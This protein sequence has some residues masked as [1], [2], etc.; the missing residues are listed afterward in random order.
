MK[1]LCILLCAVA[2]ASA[3][4]AQTSLRG[5]ADS[6]KKQNS[7][8][9]REGL[10][11]IKDDSMLERFKKNKYLVPIAE[12]DG[13]VID[14]RLDEKY[15]WLRPWANWFLADM[16]GLHFTAFKRPLQINSAVRTIARQ[17]E[18]RKINGNA[19]ANSAH[20]TGS[21]LDITKANLLAGQ[22]LWMRRYLLLM[23]RLGKI[24]AT[25][26]HEQIVFHLMVF[27]NYPR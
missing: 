14:P 3:A 24:E 25:E 21:V 18:L 1:T 20:P 13:L 8:A 22:I 4:E 23:E 16:A 2:L 17:A 19:S 7:Q 6:M 27:K 12:I 10:T 5:S 26:E 15:R 9:D 11:R